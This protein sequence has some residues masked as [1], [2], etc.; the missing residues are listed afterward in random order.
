MP[1]SVEP[2]FLDVVNGDDLPD[3]Q[4]EKTERI[5]FLTVYMEAQTTNPVTGLR[6]RIVGFSEADRKNLGRD[7]SGEPD[8][9]EIAQFMN[10]TEV[11]KPEKPRMLDEQTQLDFEAMSNTLVVLRLFGPQQWHFKTARSALVRPQGGQNNANLRGTTGYRVRADGQAIP[12]DGTEPC[13]CISFL[14]G[15]PPGNSNARKTK[16][17]MVVNFLDEGGIKL[18]VLIDPNVENQG[19]PPPFIGAP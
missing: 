17:L 5:R 1:S 13:T 14:V 12:V 9:L 4:G 7:F 6:F 19:K 3:R 15:D 10:C 2:R 16:V 11:I 8:P 18:P